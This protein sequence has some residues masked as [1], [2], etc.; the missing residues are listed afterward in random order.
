MG[1]GVAPLNAI[2]ARAYE[3]DAL[4][5]WLARP[6]VFKYSGGGEREIISRIS[7]C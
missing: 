3:I 7:R 6:R 4:G 5:L 1:G 2:P